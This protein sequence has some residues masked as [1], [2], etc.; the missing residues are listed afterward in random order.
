MVL[1]SSQAA[2]TESNIISKD[3]VIPANQPVFDNL[4][5]PSA[6]WNLKNFLKNDTGIKNKLQLILANFARKFYG[7]TIFRRYLGRCPRCGGSL[8]GAF[9][10]HFIGQKLTCKLCRKRA[11]KF[12]RIASFGLNVICRA[13]QMPPGCFTYI[14]QANE[15][16]CTLLLNYLE[17]LG[18]FGLRIPFIP[19]GPV[20]TIWSI[21]DRCNLDCKHCYMDK[22][23]VR[24]EI[25]F[26]EAC[27]V[28]DQL[29]EARNM[30]LGFSGGEPLLRKDI[31]NLI[32][33]GKSK[34]MSIALATSGI[35]VTPSVASKL[36][37]A[38]L[39]HI[40]ISID[41]MEAVH[42]EIRGKGRFRQAIAGIHSA[43]E[44]GLYVSMDVVVTKRNVHQIHDLVD[45]AKTLGVQK[46]ELLDFVPCERASALQD[47]AL[48]PLEIERFALT[49][50]KIWRDLMERNYPLTLSYKNPIFTRILSQR[51]PNI[52]LMPFFKG[53]FPKEALKFFNFSKR[54]Q[55]GVFEE[56][57]P[58][59]PFITG[60][61]AGFYIIHIKPT[62]EITPCPLNPCVLGNIRGN[63][64]RDVWQ[65]S[66]VLNLYRDLEFE[67]KCGKCTHKT[68]CGGCRAKTYVLEG[69]LGGSDPTCMWNLPDNRK[70][71][72]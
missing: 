11:R 56:Q 14:L 53:V 41:G 21:T 28:I 69:K 51:F 22:N 7:K 1:N 17:G 55:K 65:N 24:N 19:A 39:G 49:V 3:F 8:A 48:S 64:I 13:L 57:N 46:F 10:E 9:I 62:G 12:N 5:C 16:L 59:S 54:L 63:H 50:C 32:T 45:L 43:L 70:K 33:Y 23:R 34:G 38:G 52:Q 44:A 29:V 60:C 35:L 26:E 58:F 36:K 30:I 40:Q 67:G 18:K 31:F 27:K 25:T 20:L 15:G 37:C 71:L 72:G 66:P 2:L 6:G 47:E 68:T 4:P 42:D 61:E